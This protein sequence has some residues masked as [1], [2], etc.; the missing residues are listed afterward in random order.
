MVIS[1]NKAAAL[2]DAG[3]ITDYEEPQ[4]FPGQIKHDIVNACERANG[5]HFAF[6]NGGRE[7]VQ[8]CKKAIYFCKM[9]MS[10]C[11]GLHQLKLMMNQNLCND[12]IDL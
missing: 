12:G 4:P 3:D 10:K 9:Q 1:P 6:Q 8:I 7:C 2:G 5:G 11:I